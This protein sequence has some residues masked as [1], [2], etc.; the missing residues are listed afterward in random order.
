MTAAV[1]EERF[2]ASELAEFQQGFHRFGYFTAN[3]RGL[4]T[5]DFLLRRGLGCECPLPCLNETMAF[6]PKTL[7]G[8]CTFPVQTET[9]P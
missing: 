7:S 8:E 9:N 3:E 4:V 6:E 1:V 2:T 5:V